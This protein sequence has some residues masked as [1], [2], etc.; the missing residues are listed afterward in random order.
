MKK[1]IL[2]PVGVL[3]ILISIPYIIILLIHHHLTDD[4]KH[5]WV[6]ISE[7]GRIQEGKR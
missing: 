3:I 1:I 5:D 2:Y 6:R 7:Y 4:I